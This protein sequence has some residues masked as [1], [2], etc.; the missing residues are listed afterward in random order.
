MLHADLVVMDLTI[1]PAVYLSSAEPEAAARPI[2]LVKVTFLQLSDVILT[3]II[4]IQ[5][6]QASIVSIDFFKF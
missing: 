3:Y 5:I 1:R 2:I 4:F 6:R